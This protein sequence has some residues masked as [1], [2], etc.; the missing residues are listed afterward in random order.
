MRLG[1]SQDRVWKDRV[2]GHRPMTTASLEGFPS[3]TYVC[4]KLETDILY[5][6]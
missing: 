3:G 5:Q 4:E 6:L 1:E 2:R